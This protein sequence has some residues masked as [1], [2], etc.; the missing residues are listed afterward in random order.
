MLN[1]AVHPSSPTWVSLTTH[2]VWPS[3]ST[4]SLC[5]DEIMLFR[6]LLLGHS[7]AA[8]NQ[9]DPRCLMMFSDWS[10]RESLDLDTDKRNEKKSLE[11]IHLT[12]DGCEAQLPMRLCTQCWDSKWC[13]PTMKQHEAAISIYFNLF[14]S[15]SIYFNLF[16]SI[17]YVSECFPKN[18]KSLRDRNPVPSC[19]RG[20][21]AQGSYYE[22]DRPNC[23]LFN[24]RML[25][26][27]NLFLYFQTSQPAIKQRKRGS[28]LI[29]REYLS[30]GVAALRHEA[31]GARKCME[32]PY[33]TKRSHFE[34]S[35]DMI[36]VECDVGRCTG[37]A[38]QQRVDLE[39]YST[40]TDVNW[41]D[42]MTWIDMDWYG[43]IWI[44]NGIMSRFSTWSFLLHLEMF[45][46]KQAAAA[47]CAIVSGECSTMFHTFLESFTDQSA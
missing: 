26:Y 44:D 43:L 32:M 40:W 45:V 19:G 12:A 20:P 6:I 35:F 9:N 23:S 33:V 36:V 10:R 8:I 21:V 7:S 15:I 38:V 34:N 24:L 25:T 29:L 4:L 37:M 3:S 46:E 39:R 11:R 47:V 31:F 13:L 2:R 41:H 17:S 30:C 14:Q 5:T 16:Q 28:L 27:V 22:R 18:P 1:V 42:G